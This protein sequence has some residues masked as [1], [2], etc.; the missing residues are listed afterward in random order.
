MECG[1]RLSAVK[2]ALVSGALALGLL[3]AAL[4]APSVAE[5][6]DSST[7][8]SFSGT[9]QQTWSPGELDIDW[10]AFAAEHR[11]EFERSEFASA[12]DGAADRADAAR[13][14]VQAEYLGEASSDATYSSL[15]QQRS[16]A[17]AQQYYDECDDGTNLPNNGLQA[18][19]QLLFRGGADGVF[20]PSYNVP[21][22]GGSG[23]EPPPRIDLRSMF[24]LQTTDDGGRFD[25]TAFLV[26]ACQEWGNTDRGAGGITFGLYVTAEEGETQ[27]PT[28]LGDPEAGPDF[29]VSIFPENNVP[30]RPLQIMAVRTPSRNASTWTVTWL[31]E[32]QRLDGYEIDGVVPTSAI[33]DFTADSGFAWTVEVVDTQTPEGGRDWFPERNYLI[34]VGEGDSAV[35]GTHVPQFPVPE[36]CGLQSES[37]VRYNLEPQAVPNDDGYPV[38][39]YHPQIA[40][41]SAWDTIRDSSTGGRSR[42]VTVAVIDSGIDSTRFD[43][44]AGGARVVAGLDAVY[45]LELEGGNNGGAIG[46]FIGAQATGYESFGAAAPPRNSDRGPHGTAVA[47]LI[48]ATGNNTIGI[49]GVDWGVRLMPIRVNDVNECID[50]VVVAE[51]IKWAVDH[52]AD[53]IHISLGSPETAD[54]SGS[55]LQPECNDGVDNDG[56]GTADGEDPGCVNEQDGSEGPGD[57]APD[58]TPEQVAACADHRDNDGDGVV[59]LADDDCEDA[60]DNFESPQTPLVQPAEPM[61][62]ADG[63]DNDGD[64]FVDATDNAD[65]GTVADPGCEGE[66]DGSE[67]PSLADVGTIDELAPA[68]SDGRDNNDD[69]VLAD[70]ED[71][72]CLNATD[73]NEGRDERVV[74]VD[75][76]REVIDYA[77]EQGVPVVAAAGNRGADD[78]PVFYPAA[79]PGV[80]TVGASDRS[81]E[82]A[83]YSSTGR[84]LDIIAPGGNNQGTLSQDIAAL[85]E[86]DRIRPVA[87]SSFAAPLVTGAASLYLGLNPH[88]TRGFT[89]SAQP[90]A[91]GANLPDNGYQRTV[92][93]VKIALQ[94]GVRD[95][96]PQGHDIFNG[97]GRLNVDRVL[98]IPALGGPLVDPARLQLPRTNADS[99]IEVAEGVALSRPLVFPD[100]VV[101]TRND[102]AVD[103]LAGASLLRGGPLL[104]STHDAVSDSTMA[105]M[106]EVLPNGGRVYVLGGE[107]ALSADIDTQLASHGYEVVR[108]AGDSRVDTALA[109]AEEVRRVYPGSTTVALARSDGGNDPTAQW[110][111]ALSG[112]AWTASTGTPLLVTPGDQLHPGV[113]DALQRWGTQETILFGGEAALSQAVEAAVP[114]ARR[115]G[116]ADRAATA[117]MIAEDLWGDTEGFMVANGYYARGWPAGLAAAGW[118]ADVN[119]PLL[120]T[121]A[122]AV[123]QATVD[124]LAAACPD[125]DSMQIVGGASLVTGSAETQL[126]EAATCG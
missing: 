77:L 39:W 36:T 117:A 10:A 41:P 87:G 123:P 24:I 37:A 21:N 102:V 81:G 55:D 112:G 68:C 28:V 53:I 89:P 31:D 86:L 62:C 105:A 54:G 13:A 50:N 1:M 98:D 115:I 125:T 75:P 67:G 34:R 114:G 116:G 73:N 83:F 74:N 26:D 27:Y 90:P 52:G 79:Y 43:F 16:G 25:Q 59:D 4:A 72:Q 29:V 47:S 18:S 85:W 96:F 57:N 51:G 110:A 119:A 65:L 97:W 49:A 76:L 45:G 23:N 11:E 44:L 101:L 108:L 82:R 70:A 17:I 78:D 94:N 99:V 35:E 58:S 20:G 66:D 30:G 46:P 71:A 91:P 6:A 64:G 14:A 61:E 92:D 113:A 106:A 95:L 124:V 93:D 5:P 100:F 126:L 121:G 122:D 8:T 88:I 48:G 104:V 109:I 120:Y 69:D 19:R 80:L 3:P 12:G 60:T 63:I 15:E 56:D 7:D 103:A 107:A 22:P 32:A 40:T 84:W 38:Q 33:G 118:G 9:V 2:T 42:P 111:D